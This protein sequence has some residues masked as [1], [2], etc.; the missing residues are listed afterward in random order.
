MGASQSQSKA[1]ANQR[2]H[3]LNDG[4]STRSR[5]AGLSLGRR[6]GSA[7]RSKHGD[8]AGRGGAHGS[9]YV[10]AAAAATASQQAQ[11]ANGAVLGRKADGNSS[12]FGYA[13]GRHELLAGERSANKSAPTYAQAASAA[14]GCE[15]ASGG[16]ARYRQALEL[17]G[18]LEQPR[19]SVAMAP[20]GP[21]AFGR[22][23]RKASHG[24]SADR[25]TRGQPIDFHQAAV[26]M[27]P[28][29]SA[30]QQQQYRR[31]SSLASQPARRESAGRLLAL[32]KPAQEQQQVSEAERAC[33]GSLKRAR[34]NAQQA[35]YEAMRT[36]DMYLVRQIARSCK[37][38]SNWILAAVGVSSNKGEGVSLLRNGQHPPVRA[39]R[40]IV[41]SLARRPKI[42]SST[43][44]ARPPGAPRL[45]FGN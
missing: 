24:G 9:Y 4:R 3:S 1:N 11:Q 40:A 20:A 15:L 7:A 23:Q 38:S 37:V 31:S 8:P 17:A 21:L 13:T 44:S 43:S 19:R 39:G 2:R 41:C 42:S 18:S 16:G 26:P 27:Q 28:S 36:I 34:P 6:G 5:L 35:T 45:T 22:V 12:R 29:S 32:F 30:K 10:S 25:P 14:F 33:V